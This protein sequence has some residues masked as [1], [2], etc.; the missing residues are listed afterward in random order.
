MTPR[1]G[2]WTAT[3]GVGRQL[4]WSDRSNAPIMAAEMW[5]L[6]SGPVPGKRRTPSSIPSTAA[7][8]ARHSVVGSWVWSSSPKTVE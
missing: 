8:R 4:A 3:S 7:T 6:T 5:S 1:T 2:R